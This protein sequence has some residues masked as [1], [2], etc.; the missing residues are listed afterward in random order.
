MDGKAAED[1]SNKTV[2]ELKELCKAQG[3]KVSGTKAE[4]I[5]RLE[6]VARKQRILRY[7]SLDALDAKDIKAL[8]VALGETVKSSAT[9]AAVYDLLLTKLKAECA[10]LTEE[11]LRDDWKEPQTLSRDEQIASVVK[12]VAGG[13][14]AGPDPAHTLVDQE[15]SSHPCIKVASWNLCNITN[16][17]RHK[18]YAKVC[19]ILSQFDVIAV[20]EVLKEDSLTFL[21][22]RLPHYSFVMSANSVGRIRKEFYAFIWNTKTV[23]HV[24]SGVFDDSTQDLYEREPFVGTFKAVRAKA[25]TLFDFTLCTIHV[26]FGN[27]KKE[28]YSEIQGLASVAKKILEANGKERDVM[29]LGD[30]NMEPDDDCFQD[31]KAVGFDPIFHP[32]VKTTVGDVSLY[33]NIWLQVGVTGGNFVRRGVIEFDKGMETQH[34]RNTISDHRLGRY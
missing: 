23:E 10:A 3:L 12:R 28:R 21:K 2:A 6:A 16:D 5:A 29:I 33:D 20:Q 18:D 30:F 4:L 7:N 22:E 27:S 15:V 19:E 31:L 17:S 8:A 9:K 32:P 34:A 25:K 11:D 26:L 13:A 14:A 1:Y 24:Q